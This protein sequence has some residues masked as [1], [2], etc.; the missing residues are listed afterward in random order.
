MGGGG[1]HRR[2]SPKAMDEMGQLRAGQDGDGEE[3]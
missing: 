2:Y 1:D 3:F